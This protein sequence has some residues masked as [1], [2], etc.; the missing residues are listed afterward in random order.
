MKRTQT[1]NHKSSRLKTRQRGSAF[2]A[3][4]AYGCV[5]RPP[6]RCEGEAEP[7]NGMVTKLMELNEAE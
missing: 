5:Y 6:F 2:V 3:K 7:V 4:G 1:R